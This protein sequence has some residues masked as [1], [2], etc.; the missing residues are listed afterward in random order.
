M[1][2]MYL[3]IDLKTF[4]A[5]VECV[6]RHLNPFTT[7][8][9]VADESRGKGAI[10]LAIS[11]KLK[12]QGVHNRC[13]L[14]EIPNNIKYIIAKPRMK[15]YIEYSANIYGIYLK[16]ISKDDIHVY[17]VDEAFLYVT[18]YLKT[19]KM[20]AITLAKTITK[21]IYD[22][23][24]ITATAGIGTNMYLA[25]IA[26]DLMSKHSATNIGYLDE[27]IYK[28]ELWHHRPLT[29]FWQVGRGIEARLKKHRIYDMYDV[30]HANEK[31]LYKEFGVNAQFLI[32]HSKGIETCTIKDIKAYT[33]KS[34]S[35]STSQILF[36]DYPY[37]KARLVLKEMIETKCLELVEK[38][39]VTD[40]IQLYIGYSKDVIRPS[41]GM[42]KMS[43]KT[44]NYN[45]L[46]ESFL[47][48]YD[49]TTNI[50]TPI[51][52]IGIAFAKV[53]EKQYEQM[54]L[55]IDEKKNTKEE[56]VEKAIANIKINYG[57]NAIIRAMS[58]QEGATA[59]IRN[60]LVGG[61]N[62]E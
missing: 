24:G 37:E 1:E 32:D 17:S 8:L 47:S 57:K 60:K 50:Y 42:Y 62:G 11:P 53:E 41:G 49:K 51:R 35:I 59:I 43:M 19:Y 28:K 14:F 12:M 44:N 26:L 46:L 16:Y 4:Y 38:N 23:Y 33:P 40:T 39:L 55:F 30:A 2:D 34:N 48:L 9:V 27:E 56:N 25:K 52:R 36:E 21:D 45:I 5:S 54:N 29:D 13:R 3:C 10:C 18:P 15:K 31:V 61:H 6:E 20:D 58:L 22:T 7:N